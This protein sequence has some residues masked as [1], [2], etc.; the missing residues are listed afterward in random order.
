MKKLEVVVVGSGPSALAT[1]RELVVSKVAMRISVVDSGNTEEPTQATGMKSHFGSLHMYDQKDLKHED[2]KSVVWPSSSK[3]GFSR[4]WGAVS[5]HDSN[6]EFKD[7]INFNN[8]KYSEFKTSSAKIITEN[9]YSRKKKTWKLEEHRVAVNSK[10]CT[11]CGNCL[12]GCPTNAIWFAGDQWQEFETIRHLE[13]FKVSTIHQ[14]SA[15]LII[16][17]NH[18]ESL[19]CDLIFLAA[20]PIASAQILMRSKLIDRKVFFDDTQALFF[21]P[22]EFQ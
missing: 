18:N 16:K 10:L 8:G 17:S 3:G 19:E 13:N 9:Y 7:V 1:V 14:T 22:L 21:P 12:T 4:I 5:G 6:N 11:M 15:K 20:G 2:M